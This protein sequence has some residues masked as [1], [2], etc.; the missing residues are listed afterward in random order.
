MSQRNRYDE[1]KVHSSLLAALGRR[2]SLGL[3]EPIPQTPL[4]ESPLFFYLPS[5]FTDKPGRSLAVLS[6]REV[7]RDA[8]GSL[9]DLKEWVWWALEMGRRVLRDRK[10]IS[11]LVLLVDALGAGYRNIVSE[12]SSAR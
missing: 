9:E 11:G 4:A 3:H 1:D 10:S 5:R 6:L 8:E 2:I 12:P 7:K